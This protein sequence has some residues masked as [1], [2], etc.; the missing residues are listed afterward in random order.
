MAVAIST[1]MNDPSTPATGYLAHDFARFRRERLET[2][3]LKRAKA[4]I[5]RELEEAN[6][7]DGPESEEASEDEMFF[8]TSS[9]E[10]RQLRSS[11]LSQ[12]ESRGRPQVTPRQRPPA[13][14]LPTE[15]V[16]RNT[17]PHGVNIREG[18][19][20]RRAG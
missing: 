1:P 11:N 5:K 2:Q 19:Q 10:R 17:P 4:E 15:R 7:E 8:G 14:P 3:R 18:G 6:A 16:P 20:P 13:P 9:M 12:R